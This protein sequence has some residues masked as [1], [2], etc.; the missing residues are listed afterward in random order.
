LQLRQPTA[1]RQ[2][3]GDVAQHLDQ[4]VL[5]HLEGADRPAELLA[6]FGVGQRGFVGAHHEAGRLP[7]HAGAGRAQDLRGV[8]EGVG[9]LQPVRL[10]DAA[11]LEHDVR[12]LHDAQRDLVLDLRCAEPGHLLLDDEPEDALGVDVTGPDDDEIGEGRVPDPPL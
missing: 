10:R 12:V 2:R 8:A 5:D 6:L 7:G 4:Q 11:L 9:V 1:E 3:C